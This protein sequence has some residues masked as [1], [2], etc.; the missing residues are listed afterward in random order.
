MKW[1]S[2][3]QKQ[4]LKQQGDEMNYNVDEN[5]E[6]HMREVRDIIEARI[7]QTQSDIKVTN[8]NGIEEMNNL[9]NLK[10]ED[11]LKPKI[12]TFN[13]NVSEALINDPSAVIAIL[14]AKDDAV[15]LREE[16][17]GAPKLTIKT[18]IKDVHIITI[19]DQT[20]YSKITTDVYINPIINLVTKKE[21]YDEPKNQEGNQEENQEDLNELIKS[22]IVDLSSIKSYINQIIP[23]L[24]RLDNNELLYS[25]IQYWLSSRL[26]NDK[27]KF[28]DDSISFIMVKMIDD[29][30]REKFLHNNFTVGEIR[31]HLEQFKDSDYVY[32]NRVPVDRNEITVSTVPKQFKTVKVFE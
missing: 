24:K 5:Q 4:Y 20:Q 27:F 19:S 7:R 28:D 13:V 18:P 6:K 25:S 11:I 21:L 10:D 12:Y 29:K 23:E 3:S 15:L 30:I 17:R 9:N 14:S 26:Y 16:I 2:S 8:F 31:R 22:K 1:L 32:F